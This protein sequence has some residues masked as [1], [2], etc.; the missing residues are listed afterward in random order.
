MYGKPMI[1]CDIGSGMSYINIAGETGLVIP[2]RDASALA[3]AMQ[4]LWDDEPQAAAMGAAA[5][6]RFDQVFTAQ[7]MAQSYVELY[8]DVLRG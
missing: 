3:Q 1:S 7:R 6:Q 8:H 2:P 5:Q 4:T